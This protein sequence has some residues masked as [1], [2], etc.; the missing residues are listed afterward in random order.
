MRHRTSYTVFGKLKS[1]TAILNLRWHVPAVR[2]LPTGQV[3]TWSI[4][5][6]RPVPEAS[7]SP[8]VNR[9]SFLFEKLVIKFKS[10]NLEI[11]LPFKA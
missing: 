7:I 11:N 10:Y 2:Y 6:M 9:H 8:R 1:L 4:A 5:F 3:F